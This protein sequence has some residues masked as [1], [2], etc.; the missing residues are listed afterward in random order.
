MKWLAPSP[1]G[2]EVWVSEVSRGLVPARN[3]RWLHSRKQSKTIL[4]IAATTAFSGV[5]AA[6]RTVTPWVGSERI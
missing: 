3:I 5:E 2:A 4:G 6:R 1:S